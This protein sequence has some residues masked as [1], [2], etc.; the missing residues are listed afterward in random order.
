[1]KWLKIGIISVF[2]LL[3][4]PAQSEQKGP[5]SFG[6]IT[7]LTFPFSGVTAQRMK[8]WR[9]IAIHLPKWNETTEKALKSALVQSPLSHRLHPMPNRGMG[10]EVYSFTTDIDFALRRAKKGTQI[11]IGE[12]RPERRIQNILTANADVDPLPKEVIDALKAGKLLAARRALAKTRGK[13]KDKQFL[14]RARKSAF[15]A[16]LGGG[17]AAGCPALPSSLKSDR[18]KEGVFL[19]AWCLRETGKPKIALD[20]LASLKKESL[21]EVLQK[22]TTALEQRIAHGLV[23]A[24]DRRGDVINASACIIGYQ[25]I[26]LHGDR[27]IHFFETM[28]RNLNAVGVGHVFTRIAQREIST[29]AEDRHASALAPIIAEAYLGSHQYVRSLDAATFFLR[30]KQPDLIAAR[31]KRVRGRANLQQ[32]DW[33]F[34]VSDLIAAQKTLGEGTLED[35]LLRLEARLR[36]GVPAIQLAPELD[37]AMRHHAAD[38]KSNSSFW[39]KRLKG[40]MILYQEDNPDE[41]MLQVL[42]THVLVRAANTAKKNNSAALGKALLEQA[43]KGEGGWRDLAVLTA[44]VDQMRTEIDQIRKALEVMP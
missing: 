26:L 8:G 43:T 19:A 42:P 20:Y 1:M 3:A 12:L 39:I 18:M 9:G 4:D 41:A 32:G 37:K 40:E 13:K 31:L 23:T 2:A 33:Q 29:I 30:K 44:E 10:I 27:D 14:Y 7:V 6:N 16:A 34:A 15:L 5:W 38:A 24:N 25:D 17:Y 35:T 28:T 22:N 11:I 36:S 21:S